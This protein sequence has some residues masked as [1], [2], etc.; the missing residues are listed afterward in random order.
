MDEV[1]VNCKYFENCEDAPEELCEL[2][3]CGCFEPR[4]EV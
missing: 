4:E 2:V 3:G 1:C